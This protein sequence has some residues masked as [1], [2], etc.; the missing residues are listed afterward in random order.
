M[1][2]ITLIAVLTVPLGALSASHALAG[3]AAPA[4]AAGGEAILLAQATP[5]PAT[6]DD[7]IP[8]VGMD[9]IGM[10]SIGMDAIGW[11]PVPRDEGGA[12]LIDSGTAVRVAL[13]DDEIAFSAAPAE[14][15]IPGIGMDA[16]NQPETIRFEVVNDGTRRHALGLTGIIGG[17]R[18]GLTIAALEPGERTAMALTL[19]VGTYEVYDPLGNELGGTLSVR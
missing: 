16:I 1:R 17:E 9:A 6:T 8:G 13:Q 10:E 15:E 14:A 19:P 18:F 3:D 7:Q 4:R 12:A 2:A 5:P 11:Q